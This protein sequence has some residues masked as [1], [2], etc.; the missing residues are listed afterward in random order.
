M[1]KPVDV[2]NDVIWKNIKAAHCKAM[3]VTH[4]CAPEGTL[5]F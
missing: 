3:S 4:I 2:I 5:H 1:R